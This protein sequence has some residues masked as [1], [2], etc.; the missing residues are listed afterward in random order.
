MYTKNVIY[1]SLIKY[2]VRQLII[3]PYKII[4]YHVKLTE[5]FAFVSYYMSKIIIVFAN[6]HDGENFL[7]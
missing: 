7:C 6:G 4:I 1:S 2:R 5:N 3:E